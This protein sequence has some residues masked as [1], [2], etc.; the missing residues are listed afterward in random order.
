MA[1]TCVIGLWYPDIFVV[2]YTV[3]PVLKSLSAGLFLIKCLSVERSSR[4]VLLYNKR[5]QLLSEIDYYAWNPT[6]VLKVH[7]IWDIMQK[8]TTD[9]SK[10]LYHDHAMSSLD[11][12]KNI[13]NKKNI[14]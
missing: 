2:R 7:L 9:E 12:I 14:S 4:Q 3:E 6:T 10:N 5:C 11:S 8:A 13:I 1:T